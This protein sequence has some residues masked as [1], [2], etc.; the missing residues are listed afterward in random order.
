MPYLWIGFF[1]FVGALLFLDLFV[2]N[3][4]DHVPSTREALKWTALWTA[5]GLG[6]SGVIWYAYG[7]GGWIESSLT[8]HQATVNY[9][10]GYLVELSLSMDNVFVIALIFAYFKTPAMY[11]HRVL[12][13]CILGAVVMRLLMIVAGV[14]LLEQFDWM[15]YVFG[16]LLLFSALK[17]VRQSEEVHPSENPIILFVKKVVPVT[18]DYV[19]HD[20]WTRIEG[21][22]TATPLFIALVMVETTDVIFAVDSIPAILGI[23]T[24]SF[25]VFSSNILAILGLRSLY[26][27]LASMIDKFAYLKYSLALILV[28]VGVKMLLHGVWHPAEW[29]SLVVI[30]GLLAGGIALSLLSPRPAPAPQDPTENP[31]RDEVPK[32][33]QVESEV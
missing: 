16:A 5:I 14:Y 18:N 28:F 32:D 1:L 27:V 17:M 22:L 7:T 30:F 13:W 9:L 4:K 29:V 11:Q 10:T 23:T 15:F 12:F 31:R 21:K 25:L 8:A 20:F 19:G 6:F 33:H 24:D 3:K 26:F 2:L